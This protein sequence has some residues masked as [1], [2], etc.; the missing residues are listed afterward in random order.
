M[1]P[2]R[3]SPAPWCS[4]WGTGAALAPRGLLAL[5]H[6]SHLMGWKPFGFLRVSGIWAHTAWGTPSVTTSCETQ[7]GTNPCA[8]RAELPERLPWWDGEAG[9]PEAVTSSCP[10]LRNCTAAPHRCGA[11]PWGRAG[12]LGRRRVG[13]GRARAEGGRG[14]RGPGAAWG[15]F[16][17]RGSQV[18]GRKYTPWVSSSP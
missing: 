17:T 11:A 14:K 13:P 5:L 9:E 7:I 6:L 4:G 2:P 15:G 3:P 12:P 8:D 16:V 10:P 1:S 18:K